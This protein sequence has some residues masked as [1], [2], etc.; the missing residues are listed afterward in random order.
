MTKLFLD[1]ETYCDLDIKKVGTYKYVNHSSFH[2]WCAAYTL[3]NNP[4]RLWVEGESLP[5]GLEWAFKDS[6]VKI[7]A[8][9]AEFELAVI[10]K[11]WPDL[12]VT[13]D[14]F[15]D[16]MALACTYGYPLNMGN[17]GK[18]L[19]VSEDRGKDKKGKAL[20]KKLCCLQK[21]T[22][23]N[24]EG[25]W[26]PDT[27]PEDFKNLYDY[28]KQDVVAMREA[29]NRLPG[30]KLSALEHLIWKHTVLQNQRGLPIDVETVGSVRQLLRTYNA[31]RLQELS[32]ITGGEVQTGKQVQKIRAFLSDQGMSVPNL[33]KE[34]VAAVLADTTGLPPVA[35]RVLELRHLLA[36]SSTAKFDSMHYRELNGRVRGNLAYHWA[37][38]GRFAGRG[39]QAHNLPRATLDDPEATIELVNRGDYYEICDAHPNVNWTCSALIRP[40]I[41][42]PE[43]KKLIVVDYTSIE[44]VLLHWLA[45]DTETL[46]DFRKGIDQYKKYASRR[47]NVPYDEVTKDQRTY[48]KP[49]ILG[50]GFGGAFAAL[51][52]I[53]RNYGLVL[54]VSTA[55]I[56]VKFYRKMYPKIPKLWYAVFAKA[57]EA[58]ISREPQVLI[59]QTTQVEF[60]YAGGYLFILLPSGRRIAYPSARAND[61]WI[62]TIK[63]KPVQFEA[64]ISYI[65]L[66]NGVWGRHG[67]HPGLMAE[68]IVQA[69]ARDTLCYGMLCAEQGGYPVVLSVHDEIVTEVPDNSGYTVEELAELA[70]SLQSWSKDIPV[71]A[72]GYEG[73]RYKKE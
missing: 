65:G 40:C 55:K 18:A 30:E 35:I 11:R 34:T 44:N 7:L 3:E 27:A 69:L 29:Y 32:D 20:I 17:L 42:A 10:N 50:L 59:T 24:T 14:K 45:G 15:I 61:T 41:K 21:K 57:K 46:E 37:H 25:R 43:G 16:V 52:K 8:F 12:L 63:K 64:G 49:C 54:A 1:F 66:K 13:S 56:D 67:I 60:R 68:N 53:A 4:V 73:Y 22:A 72:S 33:Q 31:D 9:N 48:A 62:V 28:C 51:M 26:Y 19:G 5:E 58:I 39:L 38:T 36:H 6:C 47:F 2:V 71:S 23:F 70:C